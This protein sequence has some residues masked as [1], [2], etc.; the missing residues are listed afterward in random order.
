M[1][2]THVSTII[3]TL[4]ALLIGCATVP[5]TGRQQLTLIPQSELLGMSFDQYHQLITESKLSTNQD[6]IALVRKV[7]RNIAGAANQFMKE[8]GMQSQASSY[9]WEFNLIQEDSTV[10]AFCMPGGKVAVYTGIL[11]LT[12]DETG[13]AV[14]VGHEV[15]HAMANHGG[16]RMSQGLI[17]Q[18]GGMTLQAALSKKP[19]TTQALA[20]LAYGVG[21]QVG[22]LLPYSRLHESEA[23][24]I[25]LI[26]MAR[27][28]Y[29]P[30]QA[31]PFWE[32]M[33]SMGGAKP[34]ELLSTHPADQ[35]RIAD[36]QKEIPE[37]LQY[38]Q[39]GGK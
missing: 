6:Q 19:E 33:A 35:R 7:G 12:Q 32:R 38:Y 18:L 37:A 2:F 34:P 5:L 4:L 14:V 11:P 3:I 24:H 23:D 27:A 30:R 29:D 13:L 8:N 16:E 22:V 21:S 28:G 20:M 9:K 15:A 1:K 31:V 39:P 10:N 17:Q 26:L 36:I 25:G